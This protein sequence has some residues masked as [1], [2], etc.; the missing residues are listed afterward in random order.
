[1][2][3][4][5]KSVSE[6]EPITGSYE[7]ATAASGSI[8]RKEFLTENIGFSQCILLHRIKAGTL[9]DGSKTGIPVSKPVRAVSPRL[10]YL[11]LSCVCR[12]AYPEF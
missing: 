9:L 2:R 7:H 8:K 10:R 5:T 11:V 6:Q 12:S 3:I 1:M 4:F